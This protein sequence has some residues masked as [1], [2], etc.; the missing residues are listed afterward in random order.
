MTY[1]TVRIHENFV[2]ISCSTKGSSRKCCH[3]FQKSAQSML[4]GGGQ[5]SPYGY[6]NFDYDALHFHRSVKSTFS[7]YSFVREGGGHKTIALCTL[8]IMLSIMDDPKELANNY[9]L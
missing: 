1:M 7:K 3:H 4:G 5:W 6:T 8:F 2:R 9:V